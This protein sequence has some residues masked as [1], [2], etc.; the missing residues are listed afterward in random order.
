MST[1]KADEEPQT[2]SQCGQLLHD[3]PVI[4][5]H[6]LRVGLACNQ[7]GIASIAEPLIP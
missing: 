7:H 6:A 3:E 5:D 2:C 4:V 1:E